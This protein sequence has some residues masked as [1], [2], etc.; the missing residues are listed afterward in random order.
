MQSWDARVAA[1]EEEEEE[2]HPSKSINIFNFQSLY[3]KMHN[4]ELSHKNQ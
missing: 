1:K 3:L 4:E 2:N